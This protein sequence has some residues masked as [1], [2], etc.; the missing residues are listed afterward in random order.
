MEI[1]ARMMERLERLR[2]AVGSEREGQALA[3]AYDSMPP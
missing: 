1:P 3:A 2:R